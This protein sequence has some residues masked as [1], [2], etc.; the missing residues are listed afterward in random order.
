MKKTKN[1]ESLKKTKEYFFVKKG[2]NGLGLF[3]KLPIKKKM[4]ILE[5]V[6]EIITADEANT[7][8]GKYLFELNSKKTIDGKT[9]ENLARYINHSC[10]P[11]CESEIDGHRVFIW[12][13]KEDIKE[14]EELCYD[15]GEEY[16]DE[17]IK[18]KGCGCAKC[19]KKK[20][21]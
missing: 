5:Y 4:K 12:S 10:S 16:F 9:R 20:S 7:R 21:K 6:G 3:A 2:V 17:Y 11:N 15:Y 19:S 13:L 8:G 1:F 18:P 14:G